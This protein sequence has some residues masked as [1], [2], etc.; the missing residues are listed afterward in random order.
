[1]YQSLC[2]ANLLET[3]TFQPYIN[4]ILFLSSYSH[5]R[6]EDSQAVIMLTLLLQ[7]HCVAIK[8]L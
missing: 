2:C 1:M 7:W 6:E 3:T 5:I 8:F 4:H